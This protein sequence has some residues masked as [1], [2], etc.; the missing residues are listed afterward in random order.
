M[1]P[2]GLLDAVQRGPFAHKQ[3]EEV[4]RME[5]ERPEQPQPEE[6]QPNTPEEDDTDDE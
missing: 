4:I 2:Q 6:P 3:M 1:I 5:T